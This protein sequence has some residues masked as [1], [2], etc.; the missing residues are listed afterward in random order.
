MGSDLNVPCSFIQAP[1]IPGQDHG[2]LSSEVSEHSPILRTSK[3][4]LQPNSSLPATLISFPLCLLADPTTV[5]VAAT[6]SLTC[7]SAFS[8]WILPVSVVFPGGGVTMFLS[9]LVVHTFFFLLLLCLLFIHIAFMSHD[10]P[11]YILCR[12]VVSI[13]I[14]L[15][16]ELCSLLDPLW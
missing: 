14:P 7:A 9:G 12:K 3:P 1:Y 13:H 11:C 8:L 5:H 2:T 16:A 15:V 6:D 10:Q 4:F